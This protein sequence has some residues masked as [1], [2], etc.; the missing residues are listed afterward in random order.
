MTDRGVEDR[1]NHHFATYRCVCGG[2]VKL[3]PLQD[4]TSCCQCGRLYDHSFMHAA[5]ADTVSIDSDHSTPRV[6][7][8]AEDDPLIGSRLGHFQILTRIGDGGMGAVYRALD[9]SLQRYVALKVIHRPADDAQN[10]ADLDRLFQEARAQARVN[11]PHVAHVYYVAADDKI[12]FLAMEL[13]NHGTLADRLKQG[14]LEFRDLVR[15]AIQITRALGCAAQLD[16]VHGDIKPSNVLLTEE[17]NGKL[18]DFGL[19]RRLSS[20]STA[21][22]KVSGTPDYMAPEAT[23]GDAVDHRGDMY[24]LGVTLFQ[25]TFGRLPYTIAEECDLSDRLKIHR[26]AE[27]EF[28]ERWPAELPEAWKDIL[29]WLLDKDPDKRPQTF[30]ELERALSKVAPIETTTANFLLRSLAWVMDIALIAMGLAVIHSLIL[31]AQAAFSTPAAATADGTPAGMAGGI[32]DLGFVASAIN[33]L[34]GVALLISIGLLQAHWGNTTGKRFLQILIVDQHGLK[35]R[36]RILATRSVFQFSFA[37]CIVATG[38][39]L[40]FG[41]PGVASLLT[42]FVVLVFLVEIGS[43]LLRGGRSLHD[44]IFGTQVVLDASRVTDRR[45]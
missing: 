7:A 29:A 32:A 31:S 11:H 22:S 12:P 13:V 41:F 27:V 3:D 34:L 1:S 5:G 28:P 14:P 39:L 20:R 21:K 24:S 16:I 33:S 35:P 8:R 17:G 40:A 2:N 43:V 45:N 4:A 26:V 36:R 44:S 9:E 23:M 19:A 30:S 18:S 6:I 10:A 25:A 15:Y 37:W 38:Q 42:A